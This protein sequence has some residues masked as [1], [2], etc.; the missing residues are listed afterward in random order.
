MLSQPTKRVIQALATLEN[1]N[2][3]QEVLAWM[4]DSLDNISKDGFYTKDEAQTRWCQGAGQ[5]ITE[6]LDKARTAR[7]VIR[8]F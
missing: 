7:E 4:Q 1:D 3:F 6:F 8:K 2:D 5:V